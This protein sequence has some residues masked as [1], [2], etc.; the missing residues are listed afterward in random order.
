[1][2]KNEES[3]SSKSNESN[4]ERC[5][6]NVIFDLGGVLIDW[7]PRYLYRKIFRSEQEM[8]DFLTLVCTDN[9]NLQ[10]DAGR[11][12]EEGTRILCQQYPEKEQLIKL[13]YARWHEML[14]GAIPETVAILGELKAHDV[15]L[16]A[17]TNWSEETFWYAR[18]K[19]AFLNDFFLDI[20]VSGAEKLLKPDPRI[21]EVL[22]RRNNLLAV[23]SIFVDDNWSNVRA[24]EKLGMQ[25]IHFTAP[26]K[27]A[28]S[29]RQMHVL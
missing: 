8:E 15:R 9:W 26:D 27:L 19:F 10:Q 21:Y 20:V 18:Q 13:Y 23:E 24:A 1:M 16:Y 11:S 4:A 29:L 22:L 2:L 5:F 14:H 6:K 7:N 17:L 12:L 28:A 3:N 25:G